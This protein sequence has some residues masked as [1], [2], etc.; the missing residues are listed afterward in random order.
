MNKMKSFLATA[1]LCAAT[2]VG[3]QAQKRQ[4]SQSSGVR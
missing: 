1:F 3:A 2:S 4:L